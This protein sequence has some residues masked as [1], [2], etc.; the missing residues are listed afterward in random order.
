MRIAHLADIQIRAHSRHDEYRKSFQHLFDALDK[1]APDRIVVAGDILHHKTTL[2]PESVHLA[3]E[4]FQGLRIRARCVDII[5][6][7]HDLAMNNL[8]RMDAITPIVKALETRVKEDPYEWDFINFM[9]ESC[10]YPFHTDTM[11]PFSQ[12][13]VM[14]CVDGP[15]RWE[16]VRQQAKATGRLSIALWHGTVNGVMLDNG[17]TLESPHDLSLFDGMD[18]VMLGDIHKTQVLDRQRRIAYP[19]SYPKQSYGEGLSG[20][21]FLWDIDSATKHKLQF[22]ELPTVSPFYTTTADRALE[23]PFAPGARIR[24]Q[25]DGLDAVTKKRL[26][27][28]VRAKYQAIEV[29]LVDASTAAPKIADK[30]EAEEL[31]SI[32]TQEAL[33]REFVKDKN[34]T[35]AQM[36]KLV[37]LNKA[38]T[39]ALPSDD[40]V[41]NVRY[42]IESLTFD[43]LFSFGAGNVL[44]FTKLKGVIGVQGKNRSGKSSLVV[45][46]PLYGMYNKISKPVFKNQS[47]VNNA[48]DN[49]LC[50][51]QILLD[52]KRYSIQRTT[53]IQHVRKHNGSVEDKS[54]TA[55]EFSCDGKNLNALDRGDTDK[56]IRKVFGTAEDFLNTSVAAQFDLLGFVKDKAAER[57]KTI[58]RYFDLDVFEHKHRFANEDHKALKRELSRLAHTDYANAILSFEAAIEHQRQVQ[59]SAKSKAAQERAEAEK[60]AE[61][62][63]AL[64]L[65]KPN[66]I[67]TEAYALKS[68]YDSAV[69]ARVRASREIESIQTYDCITYDKCCMRLRL[70]SLQEEH[71]KADARMALLYDEMQELIAKKKSD[72]DQEALRV[73]ALREAADR[74]RME[75]RAAENKYLDQMLCASTALSK[76]SYDLEACKK[77]QKRAEDLKDA[78]IVSEVFTQ[79]MS[80]DGISFNIIRHNLSVINRAIASLLENNTDFKIWL[81][82]EGKEINVYFQE[83]DS[84]PRQIEICSGMEKSVAAIVIRAALITVTS[85]PVSNIFILDESLTALDTEHLETM[86]KILESLKSVFDTILVICHDAYITDLCDETITIQRNASGF[87]EIIS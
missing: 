16:E 42:A 1:V 49:A 77:E 25:C 2:S 45:D 68:K 10:V 86:G 19:G 62:L 21:F 85:L 24:I 37:A 80:K 13:V 78:F 61:E 75:H 28:Q 82:D 51:I 44:D 56:E 23:E 5:L 84:A 14:S 38:A 33:L 64:K 12:Y 11:A 65:P 59:E 52:G 46:A 70:Q 47:Y 7:N 36:D 27:E 30:I 83:N 41:R 73:R 58:G 20:G 32:P 72:A 3:I 87:S 48:K 55:V 54:T 76:A 63:S 15:E 74:K 26:T 79:A 8:S 60:A 17:T 35:P 31:R 40:V 67:N 66:V 4:L 53:S 39:D 9:R 81:A 57:K 69:T 71:E 50:S 43:N 6:G 22:I 18:Y 34:L 29:K